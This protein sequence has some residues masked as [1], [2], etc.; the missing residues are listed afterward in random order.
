MYG[1][2]NKKNMRLDLNFDYTKNE[3]LLGEGGYANVYL[4]TKN[5]EYYAKKQ[6]RI[7]NT[8][9]ALLREISYMR[10]LNHPNIMYILAQ[11]YC[12]IDNKLNN[13]NNITLDK[14]NNIENN[15]MYYIM[16]VGK[17]SLYTHSSGF[18][19]NRDN[20]SYRTYKDVWGR[21]KPLDKY[22]MYQILCGVDYMH[23]NGI[24]H[25][26]LNTR[27]IM[28]MNDN[29]IKIC[30][31]G[32]AT[33]GCDH[34]DLS[35]NVVTLNYRAPEIFFKCNYNKNV[36][37]WSLGCIFYE[38]TIGN[39]LFH[40]LKLNDK[41]MIKVIFEQL[42]FPDADI[43]DSSPNYNTIMNDINIEEINLEIKNNKINNS[44]LLSKIK[45]PFVYEM[46]L[47]LL[48]YEPN[49]RKNIRELIKDPYF[50]SVAKEEYENYDIHGCLYNLEK[51]IPDL[52]PFNSY[53]NNNLNK[54]NIGYISEY[55]GLNIY[56]IKKWLFDFNIDHNLTKS[57]FY[58]INLMYNFL[59][60][61]RKIIDPS[62]WKLMAGSCL[63]LS[64]YYIID[65]A[66]PINYDTILTK[67]NS[68][69][70]N[71]DKNNIKNNNIDKNEMEEIMQE[72]VRTFKFDF[73]YSTI[74]DFY[75]LF[76]NFYDK[77]I[78]KI[79]DGIFYMHIFVFSKD[80]YKYNQKN[81]ALSII[82]LQCQYYNIQFKHS[83]NNFSH[84]YNHLKTLL[85]DFINDN[86]E[87]NDSLFLT[88]LSSN[89][90]SSI[91]L[92]IID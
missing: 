25:R 82:Y 46:I 55:P 91:L 26:D 18:F 15:C 51:T 2:K 88:K 53:N 49:K 17:T 5:N 72:I 47:S 9:P 73:C 86:I 68:E 44:G 24:I 31:F 90:N 78:I 66:I 42:G 20:S 27:N 23:V 16:D 60:K 1:R 64:C 75:E 34:S 69:N 87:N 4:I 89:I 40:P 65:T 48:K 22:L 36:D 61:F 50:E 45:D 10:M 63:L 52:T 3:K 83:E 39:H 13:G 57:Y 67:I 28:I 37:L 79:D 71:I 56:E 81:I 92:N 29:I 76:Q 11:G 43:Y 54:N 62:S 38:I 59:I 84:E 7:E 70:N 41:Y 85:L 14:L 30:D 21:V 33:L 8:E 80:Y 19:T 12:K 74:Y 58:C 6:N 35:N 77:N 32:L